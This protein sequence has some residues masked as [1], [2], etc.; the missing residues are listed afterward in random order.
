VP[1]A[2]LLQPVA[3]PE[4]QLAGSHG[5]H[6]DP[7]SPLGPSGQRHFESDLG[8]GISKDVEDLPF[9]ELDREQPFTSRE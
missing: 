6:R 2:S 1:A 4:L 9:A 3:R 5:T 8:Y 7:I